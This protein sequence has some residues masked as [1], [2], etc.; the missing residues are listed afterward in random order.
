MNLIPR[1]RFFDLD[2]FFE[3]SVLSSFFP[4]HGEAKDIRAFSPRVDIKEKNDTYEIT[5]ELPG[6]KK[7]D[8]KVNLEKGVLSLSAETKSEKTEEEDGKVIRQERRYGTFYRSF[9]L[10]MN[11]KE[12]DINAEFNDGVLKI[13]AAKSAEE[14]SESRSISIR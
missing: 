10:G 9:D 4:T 13:V 6:V 3:P 7:E 12:D 11:V 1:N 8:I 5:A 2:S 14:K